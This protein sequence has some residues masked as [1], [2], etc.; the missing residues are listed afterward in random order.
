MPTIL[1]Q[2]TDAWK[3]IRNRSNYKQFQDL[4]DIL[5]NLLRRAGALKQICVGDSTSL[6]SVKDWKKSAFKSFNIENSEM[7]TAKN[8]YPKQ[9][10]DEETLTISKK[11]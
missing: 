7:K 5:A 11:K 9:K 1:S 3:C 4:N 10:V 6:S 2:T 8:V